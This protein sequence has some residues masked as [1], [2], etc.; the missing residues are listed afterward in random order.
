M[1]KQTAV[2]KS[3]HDYQFW[4]AQLDAY[5]TAFN[6]WQQRVKKIIKRYRAE[7]M[8]I[9]D[10]LATTR[11]T[12]N[13]LYANTSIM[14]PAIYNQMPAPMVERRNKDKDP[15]G[16]LASMILQRALANA[17]EIENFDE[18]IEQSRDD[19]L[20][21]GRATTWERYEARFGDQLKDADD[22]PAVDEGGE[23]INELVDEYSCTE[24]VAYNDFAHS[25]AKTWKGVWWVGR[26]VPMTKT[27]V[28]KLLGAKV[29]GLL[30][31][32]STLDGKDGNTG[33]SGKGSRVANV[34]EVWD[35]RAEKIY[36]LSKE[37]TTDL[38]T[39][40]DYP[41][42]LNSGFPCPRPCY[43]IITNETLVPVPDYV[44]YQD[45]ALDLDVLTGRI[46]MLTDACKAAGIVDA[47]VGITAQKLFQ[48]DELQ[49]TQV[50]DLAAKYLA[51]GGAGLSAFM[52]FTPIEAFANVIQ[53]LQQ[54]KQMRLD[55]IYQITGLGD[56][57]RG[58]TDPNETLG[59]Q[60]LKS[61][62]A[63]LRL[64]K[65]QRNFQAYV[66]DILR[67][68]AEIMC[69]QFSTPTL[70]DMANVDEM[71]P[72]NMPEP[73]IDPATG[74]MPPDPWK[75]ALE[76][77]VQLLRDDKQRTFRIDIETD[78]TIGMIEPQD[79]QDMNQFTQTITQLLQ[80]GIPAIQQSPELAPFIK[81]VIMLNLRQFKI[82]R[83]TEGTLEESLD[84]LVQAS[85]QPKPPPPDP[86][87]QKVEQQGKTDQAKL[88][89]QAQK[90]QQDAQLKVQDSQL[91]AQTDLQIAQMKG[92]IELEKVSAQE[93]VDMINA[94]KPEIT[95]LD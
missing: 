18:P 67:L 49:L 51:G 27:D 91:Q 81:E 48:G 6:S 34:W 72:D 17:I 63:N 76:Q 87:V 93:R 53:I 68:K 56:I 43:G 8:D 41:Y 4:I 78:S 21:G 36:Y 11:P 88:Q 25:L 20:F 28:T 38:L 80:Q 95:R 30:K 47:S 60:Q 77:A 74:Q 29:A 59:A 14:Q 7:S 79:R 54:Q 39:T 65:K 75:Q 16:R 92:Q 33:E 31:Y 37:Y 70:L 71:R 9:K 66:R 26:K 58:M 42:D 90:Q 62:Y 57:I 12:Y 3:T 89:L 24:Y 23:P 50:K 40:K 69:E 46:S 15:I 86:Q 10:S 13:I 45:Q 82:G 52:Q 94:T 61:T 55:D 83:Q 35:K 19:Y 84:K 64:K 44:M 22:Q 32:S 5:E 73:Q 2:D 85:S 1:A